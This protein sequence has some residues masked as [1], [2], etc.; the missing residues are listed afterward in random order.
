MTNEERLAEYLAEEMSDADRAAFEAEIANDPVLA[1]EVRSLRDTLSDLRTMSVPLE[2]SLADATASL[3]AP[4][5]SRTI[6]MTTTAR[7][8]WGWIAAAACLAFAAG[9][10][11][12]G[13]TSV[14][15]PADA[16]NT[17]ELVP[18]TV[19]VSQERLIAAYAERADNESSLARTLL[20]LG[21]LTASRRSSTSK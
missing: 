3:N 4:V 6:G 13:T 8:R 1:E 14:T 5:P 18:M 16:D 10:V 9:F 7:T 17:N 11:A 15:E 21:D 12:R 20:T 19:S 2:A